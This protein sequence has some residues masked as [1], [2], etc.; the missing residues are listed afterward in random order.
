MEPILIAVIFSSFICTAA[1]MPFWIRK[2]KQI[3]LEWRDMNK[4]NSEKNVSGSGGVIVVLGTIIGI[5]FYV[6]VLTFYFKQTS[7]NL[8][9]IFAILSSM[10]LISGVGLIDDL[11]GWKKGGLSIRSRII[12]LLFSS[13]PLVVIN[14]GVSEMLGLDFGI[15]YPLAIIPLGV[16][17]ATVGFNMV[18]GF[19]GLEAGQGIL[20]LSAMSYVSYASGN[21]WLSIV[22][23][24]M[25]AALFGFLIFNKNPSKVFPG[26]VMTYSVGIMIASIAI[27]GNAE[28]LAIFFFIPYLI[29]VLLK[30]RWKIQ[31]K[32]KDFPQN[33]GVPNEDGSLELRYKKIYS[34][35]HLAL[36]ILKKFKKKVYEKDVVVSI[37]LF[38]AVII[39]AGLIFLI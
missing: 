11:F 6:G 32:K 9:Y 23:L 3:G 12:L 5:L 7:Q 13:V 34:I 37:H 35:T 21:S 15:F 22:S 25:V 14:A 16:L 19:N 31:T 36:F 1:I 26:D 24:C 38:Q 10:F 20:I 18:A 30:A 17:G 2:A 29:E 39:L 28:K 27:L 33:F 4:Y 8:L